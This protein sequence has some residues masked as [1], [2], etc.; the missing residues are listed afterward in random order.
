MYMDI[1][2]KGIKNINWYK[3]I[4]WNNENEIIKKASKEKASKIWM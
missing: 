1:Y 2:C 4:N 3:K